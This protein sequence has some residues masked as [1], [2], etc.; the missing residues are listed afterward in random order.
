MKLL[1]L[2]KE[3]NLF[4]NKLLMGWLVRNVGNRFSLLHLFHTLKHGKLMFEHKVHK[5]LFNFLNLEE[6]HKIHWI[7]TCSWVMA[8]PMHCA[9]S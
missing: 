3:R 1:M 8:Q 2:P 6:N 9:L 5:Y 4:C 7:N